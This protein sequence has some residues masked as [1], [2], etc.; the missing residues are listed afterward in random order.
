MK[1]VF[2]PWRGN[3]GFKRTFF[4]MAIA[5]LT[6]AAVGCTNAASEDRKDVSFK[7]DAKVMQAKPWKVVHIKLKMDAKGEYTW[8]LHG[9]DV[10]ELLKV[11][12]KLQEQL[13]KQQ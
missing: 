9:D 13:K 2:P 4:C 7:K 1:R 6:A 12:A 5:L 11:N 10:D 3:R 8:E